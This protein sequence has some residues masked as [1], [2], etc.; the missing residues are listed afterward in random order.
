MT[1]IRASLR[2]ADYKILAHQV[3]ET[4]IVT[5]ALA[6]LIEQVVEVV[7]EQAEARGLEKAAKICGERAEYWYK[8]YVNRIGDRFADYRLMGDAAEECERAIRALKE[9]K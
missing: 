5:D 6:R 3:A 4:S 9:P 1:N 8:Q 7:A 2:Y